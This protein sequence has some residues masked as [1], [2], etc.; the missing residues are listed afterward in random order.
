MLFDTFSAFA[1]SSLDAT[2]TLATRSADQME[3]LIKLQVDTA[4]ELIHVN[5]ESLQALLGKADTR[6]AGDG[7]V[8]ALNMSVREQ[9]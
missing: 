3:H 6:D 1:K 8:A 9:R 4:Y 5:S 7:W 2:V